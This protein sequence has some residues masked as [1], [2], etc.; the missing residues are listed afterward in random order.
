MQ[1][2]Q[3]GKDVVSG[4]GGHTKKDIK[5]FNWEKYGHYADGFLES[6]DNDGK[7]LHQQA[8]DKDQD[9]DYEHVSDKENI[10]GD[11]QFN[12]R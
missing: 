3:E 2:N 4:T 12:S 10:E 5:Y 8:E 11:Q 7:Q 6:K 1:Y 9:L